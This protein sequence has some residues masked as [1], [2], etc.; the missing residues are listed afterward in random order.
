MC[1]INS[2]GTHQEGAVTT[3]WG[4]QMGKQKVHTF[5]LTERS[6]TFLFWRSSLL[7]PISLPNT[8]IDLKNLLATDLCEL[9]FSQSALARV[10]IARSPRHVLMGQCG[11]Q[12]TVPVHL[13]V[14]VPLSGNQDSLDNLHAVFEYVRS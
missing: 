4:L 5:G 8:K 9:C 11:I 12:K 10:E 13:M 3:S 1:S 14:A 6:Q 7:L 2:K